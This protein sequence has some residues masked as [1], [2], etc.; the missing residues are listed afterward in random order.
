M[1]TIRPKLRPPE[2]ARRYGIEPAKVIAW[3][4]QGELRAVNIATRPTG[5]PRYVIDE[6]DVL[7]FEERRAA[8]PAAKAP[9]RRRLERSDV[10]EFF[11]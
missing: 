1:G 9:R 11:Q 5:R 8:K 3:I 4:R 2:L 6:A 10:V 7:V